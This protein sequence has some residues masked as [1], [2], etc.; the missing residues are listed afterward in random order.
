[1]IYLIY[2]TTVLNTFSSLILIK[3]WKNCKNNKNICRKTVYWKDFIRWP[4]QPADVAYM[5][6]RDHK[7]IAS[8]VFLKDCSMRQ[9]FYE[10]VR[11]L[12][13][14]KLNWIKLHFS[15]SWLYEY[16]ELW[17][18]C[19][20]YS[21]LLVMII[22]SERSSYWYSYIGR[23]ADIQTADRSNYFCR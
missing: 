19:R 14:M 20:L 10:H 8:N 15:V 22:T 13:R 16:L 23:L 11:I 18:T 12:S 5:I 9:S 1:M 7:A 4:I 17:L 6:C 3:N 21:V 2:V